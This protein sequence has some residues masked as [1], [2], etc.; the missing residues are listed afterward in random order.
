M[1]S[2]G[3]SSACLQSWWWTSEQRRCTDSLGWKGEGA[4][5]AQL[6]VHF[7][8]GKISPRVHEAMRLQAAA[9]GKSLELGALG[10]EEGGEEEPAFTAGGPG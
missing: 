8:R 10:M 7:T 6:P 5:K 3:W 2:L 9:A 4:G 1:C